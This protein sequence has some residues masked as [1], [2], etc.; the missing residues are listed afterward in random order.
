[1]IQAIDQLWRIFATAMAFVIFGFFGV[2]FKFLL[3]P[4]VTSNSSDA[5]NSQL[6]ARRFVGGS[7]SYFILFLRF[8]GVIT[9]EY[10]G[11]ERLGRPGQLI[12]ANHPSLLDVVFILSKVRESNCIV[13]KDLFDNP[14]MSPALNACGFL[15]NDESL[16]LVEKCDDVL[17]S[18]QS[19]LIFPEG[20]R[21]GL[22]GKISFNRGAV[23]IGLRSASVITPIVIKVNPPTLKKGQAWYKVPKKKSHYEFIVGDDIAPQALLAE[24]PLPIAARLL[25][26]KLQNYFQEETTK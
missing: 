26:Q 20:T 17:R 24:K 3:K 15:A 10:R 14:S 19:L 22:D 16:E 5:L 11:F 18:G 6:K 13:K 12:L 21:T 4:S 2:L 23:T 9:V 25:N 1:M 7:W 8:M